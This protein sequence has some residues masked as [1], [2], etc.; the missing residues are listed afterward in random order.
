MNSSIWKLQT[1]ADIIKYT[2]ILKEGAV[3]RLEITWF[4]GAVISGED[5]SERFVNEGIWENGYK[6]KY[7]E[8]VKSIKVGD[9]IAI[10][11][12][13]TRKKDL[14]FENNGLTVSVMGIKAIGVVTHNLMDGRRLKVEW[15]PV[16]PIKEWYFYTGRN[17]IWRIAEEDGWMPKNLIDF[18]FYGEEQKI[19]KFLEDPYWKNKYGILENNQYEWTDFYQE[20]A[21]KLLDYKDNRQELL[22]GIQDIFS[23]LNLNNPL[24]KNIW[25][26]QIVY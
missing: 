14:P 6:N 12:T 21:V 5:Q 18:T 2:E 25:I 15:K 20:M 23:N 13:Y 7:L 24:F 10:K 1:F 3:E 17:T 8:M 16:N 26:K 9:K 4:V 22:E 11:S 19:E